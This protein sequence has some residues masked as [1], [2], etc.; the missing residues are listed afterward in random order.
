MKVKDLLSEIERCKQ[1][2][3]E[4]FLDWLVYTEQITE[5]DKREK[6]A[7]HQKGWGKVKDSEGWQYFEC[8]GFWTKFFKEK[9]FTINVNY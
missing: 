3:G 1:E 4:E 5:D 6:T 2:Y 9:I 7:G 8:A